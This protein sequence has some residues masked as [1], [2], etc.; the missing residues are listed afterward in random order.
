MGSTGSLTVGVGGDEGEE[1]R[2][3][4]PLRL[5]STLLERIIFC[6]STANLEPDLHVG[7]QSSFAN[8]PSPQHLMSA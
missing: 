7:F 6:I 3:S 4:I 2:R 5:T 1:K 8:S